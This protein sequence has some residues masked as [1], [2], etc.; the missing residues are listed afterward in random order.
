MFQ[1]RWVMLMRR[2]RRGKVTYW[3]HTLNARKS[4]FLKKGVLKCQLWLMLFLMLMYW[5]DKC[6]VFHSNLFQI[7]LR[8]QI[9]FISVELAEVAHLL[10]A[11]HQQ[12]PTIALQQLVLNCPGTLQNTA[13]EAHSSSNY[14]PKCKRVDHNS[15]SQNETGPTGSMCRKK[16]THKLM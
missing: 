9:W 15:R 6:V 13:Q 12:Q 11:I 7:T 2:R 16:S 10:R 3:C 1:Y 8:G 14:G 4:F 5:L